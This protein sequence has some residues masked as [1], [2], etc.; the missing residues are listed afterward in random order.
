MSKG[1]RGRE[2]SVGA[3]VAVCKARCGLVIEDTSKFFVELY[4]IL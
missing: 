1:T 4:N 3:L 2:G